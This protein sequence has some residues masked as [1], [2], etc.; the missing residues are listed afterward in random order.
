MFAMSFFG[1]GNMLGG[2]FIGTLID[3]YGS[4]RV[5]HINLIMIFLAYMTFF[6]FLIIN[7]YNVLTFVMTF[8][9]GFQDSVINTHTFEMLGF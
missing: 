4:K 5:I 1:V 7:E 8:M 2:L 6:V 3:K 9:F